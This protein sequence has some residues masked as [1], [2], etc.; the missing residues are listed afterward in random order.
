MKNILLLNGAKAFGASEGR[1]SATLQDVAFSVL[2]SLGYQVQQTHI[3]QGYVLEDEIKKFLDSDVMIYQ[4]PGW[5][6]GEPWIVKKYIDEVFMGLYGKLFSGDGRSRDDESKKY[7]SGGGDHGKK[8]LFSTTWNAPLESFTQKDQFFEGL[9]I[10]GVL[11]HLHKAHQFMG[12]QS[13]ESFTCYDV[14]KNPQ[15]EQYK[16]DYETHLRRIFAK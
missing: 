4:M 3:D 9:G 10:D 13:L 8:Y 1:L 7:G 2:S 16:K 5:W 14:I 12:L 15:V 11:F 6:M